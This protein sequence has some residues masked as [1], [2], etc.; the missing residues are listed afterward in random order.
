MLARERIAIAV[1]VLQ[2][3]VDDAARHQF[4]AGDRAADA[5]L[6]QVQQFH[7]GGGRGQADE[8]GLD[9]ARPRKQFQ[10]GGGDDAERSFGADENMA[11]VVAGIVLLQLAQ[12]VHDAAIGQHHLDADNEFA[13]DAIGERAGAAG[14]GREIAADG[15]GAFRTERQRE[16]TPSRF[17]RLLRPLQDDA[18]LDGDGVG[19]GIDLADFIES[20]QRQY[21]FAV[22]RNLSADQSGIA[23]LRHHR[24]FG[25]VGEFEDR[26]D[27]LR[28][29]GAQHQ[30]R[31]ALIQATAFDQMRRERLRVGDGI[32]V[33]DDLHE[34]RQQVGRGRAAQL[35]VHRVSFLARLKV[36]ARRRAPTGR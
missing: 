24:R 14:I 29:A 36:S 6:R 8:G 20:G 1:S 9:R 11:Q 15:A 23:A 33:A 3:K 19:R 7:G 27:F 31:T 5:R 17:R 16:Q 4:E 32:F 2:G 25:F 21:Q 18:G 10:H 12:E 22:E 35:V 34:A 26:R 13:G 28:R 30:R